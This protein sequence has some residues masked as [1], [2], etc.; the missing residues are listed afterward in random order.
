MTQRLLPVRP[1]VASALCCALG[2]ASGAVATEAPRRH[3]DLPAGD[4]ATTLKQFAADSGEQIVYLVDNV[5]GETTNGVKGEFSAREALDRMLAGTRL[6]ATQDRRTGAL[7]VGRRRTA[8][9]PPPAATERSAPPPNESTHDM[10]RKNVLS[11]LGAW[12]AVLL[13]PAEP[14][15]AAADPAPTD[16]RNDAAVVLSIFEVTGDKDEGYRS[17]QTIAGTRTLEE[18]R[19]T[20]NSISIINREL[21]DDLGVTTMAELSTFG[22]TGEVGDN[23]EANRTSYDFRGTAGTQ[24][25]NGILWLLPKDTFNLERVEILRGPT[26]FLYGEGNPGGALNQVTKQALTRNFEKV[27][28]SVGSNEAYRAELDVNR[29]IT[30]ELGVRLNFVRDESEGFLN[31]TNRS[32]TGLYLALNYRPFQGTNIHANFEY[33]RNH[34]IRGSNILADRFSTTER[35]GA[36]S[37]YAVTNGGFTYLPALGRIVNTVG[38]RFSGGTGI[39]LT[40]DGILPRKVNFQGPDSYFRQH[41]DSL[42]LT[43]DQRVVPNF[44]LQAN[45]ILQTSDRYIRTRAGSLSGGV[46]LDANRTLADGTANPN[47]NRYYTEFYDRKQFMAEP[48]KNFR[49][50][51][52]YD[53][54][55]RFTT[56][57]IMAMGSYHASTPNQRFHSEFV[58][59]ASSSFVGTLRGDNSLAAHQANLAV[60]QRNFFYRRFY[61]GDGDNAEMTRRGVIPGRSVIMRDIVADGAAGHSTRRDWRAPAYGIGASGSYFK[62]RLRSLV[63]W[64]RDSFLQEPTLDYYNHVTG[65]TYFLPTTAQARNRFYKASTNAGGVVH[66]ARFVSAYF[67]YAESVNVSN[68][69]GGVG[70]VPGTTRGL[71]LGDG[72]ET[73]LRWS[74]FGGRLESNWTYYVTNAFNNNSNPAVPTAVKNELVAYFPELVAAGIDT[75]TSVATGFEFETVANLSKQWRLTWNFSTNDLETSDRYPQLRSYQARAKSANHAIPETEQF[76][77]SAPEGTPVPGFTKIRTNLVTNYS[78]DRGPLKGFSVGGSVQYRDRGYRGNF[79]LDRDGTAEKLWT[80][81]Y[82]IWNA[83]AGYRTTILN[84]KVDFRLNLNNVFDKEYFR[85]TSLASG[86]WG[87]ER[88]FRLTARIDL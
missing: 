63:G 42:Q 7:V 41:Y 31:H 23:I 18:L 60:L 19:D 51:A 45:L 72:R 58:D 30:N 83:M 77:A 57:R 70:I 54:K 1:L 17:T 81:G 47:F 14:L 24:L 6:L 80:P 34:E 33:G 3:F 88:S 84:R 52:V 87:A 74:F 62:G 79:D 64:R 38:A 75:Q 28:L 12:L 86:S 68:G 59:P 8:E 2:V 82:T 66:L 37:A 27:S 78:F 53:L 43:V 26:A 67:N 15:A 50:T 20:P 16:G 85:S 56:Q 39:A 32:F 22:V 65:E 76:L 69:P 25:R 49:L 11:L 55:T 4:A 44:N 73:G 61:L 9:A 71:L 35:T 40:D 5:R 29:R 46:Y 36:T 13:A 48:Q 10:K 21:I